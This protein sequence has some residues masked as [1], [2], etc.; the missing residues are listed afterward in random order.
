V[1][2]WHTIDNNPVLAQVNA[3]GEKFYGRKPKPIKKSSKPTLGIVYYTCNTLAD[4][5]ATAARNQL[6][7]ARNGHELGCVSL[8][9]TD[10]GD[11]NIVVNAERGPLTMHRQILAGLERLK[12]DVVFFCEHDVLYHP[13]HFD[14]TPPR[15][16]TFYYNVNV[17][18]VRASDGHAVKTTDCKQLSGLCCWRELAVEH[19]RERVRRIEVEGFSRKNGYEPGTR[20]LPNGYDNSQADSWVSAFPNLDIRHDRTATGNHW[21]PESFRNQK[22]AAGW[23]ETD[24]EI[25]GWGQV[26]GQLELILQGLANG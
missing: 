10:F 21:T 19:Y 25:P 9:R 23:E 1:R 17:W 2:D 20:H 3:E 4:P 13:S 15:K 7:K 16:D 8:A 5:L 22:Y 24:G 11:W 14:F 26:S 12:A 18:R 6:N